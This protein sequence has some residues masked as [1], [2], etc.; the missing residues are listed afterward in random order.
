MNK[1]DR[2][3]LMEDVLPAVLGFIIGLLVG[4]S[5]WGMGGIR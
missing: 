4:Y 2:D 5:I 3:H 1:R